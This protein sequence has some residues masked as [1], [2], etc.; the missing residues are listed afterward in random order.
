MQQPVRVSCQQYM[1]LRIQMA[2]RVDGASVMRCTRP[3]AS[4]TWQKI[5]NHGAHFALHD[6]THFAVETTLGYRRGFYGLLAEG[7]DF[8]DIGGKGARGRL[9]AEAVEVEQIVGVF[10]S[11]RACGTLL[12]LDEFNQFAPRK[13]TETEVLSVRKLRAELFTRWSAV[14]AGQNLD[15]EFQPASP[16]IPAAAKRS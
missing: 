4:V 8:D 7:W 5:V 12:T 9:P 2:K 14:P 15:L 6:L 11:E 13:L 3:D 16:Q 10:D 1:M